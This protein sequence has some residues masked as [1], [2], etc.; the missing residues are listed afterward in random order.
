MAL[1]TISSHLLF[2]S[3]AIAMSCLVNGCA[4]VGVKSTLW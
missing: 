2:V 3:F 1:L 4:Y